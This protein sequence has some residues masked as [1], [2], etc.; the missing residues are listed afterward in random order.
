VTKLDFA[1]MQGLGNDFVVIDRLHGGSALSPTQ[2]R[3]IADRRNG[4]G[5]DQLLCL[6]PGTDAAEFSMS[7]FNADGSRAEQ[8]GNGVRCLAKYAVRKGFTKRDRF[9]IASSGK[10]IDLRLLDDERVSC[11]MGVP[12]FEPGLIPFVASVQAP[13]YDL[14]LEGE[15]VRIGA[16]SMGNPHAVTQVNDVRNADVERIGAL[17][18]SHSRFPNRVNASFM[19][20]LNKDEIRLRVF[21]RGVGETRACG[22]GAC[23][24]VAVGRRN[25][26]LNANV[27]VQLNGGTLSISWG[28]GSS[29]VWMTGPATW[30][31][32]G[33]IDV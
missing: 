27:N 14:P 11:D 18:E 2:L 7:I 15:I 9:A 16:V 6:E 23:A 25:G 33:K 19:Q 20:V 32:E 5:F 3:H 30:V 31:Y 24:A 21:E 13:W 29:S 1:K 10:V 4:V 17:L 8:C 26:L 22:T 28:G 12:I